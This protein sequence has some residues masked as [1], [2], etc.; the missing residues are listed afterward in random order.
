[1]IIDRSQGFW[2]KWVPWILIQCL[3]DSW[4]G[5][6]SCDQPQLFLHRVGLYGPYPG[7]HPADSL[8]GRIRTICLELVMFQSSRTNAGHPDKDQSRDLG[9]LKFFSLPLYV[10]GLTMVLGCRGSLSVW[11]WLDQ[12]YCLLL[13]SDCQ[14]QPGVL[15][16]RYFARLRFLVSHWGSHTM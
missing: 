16:T 11:Y 7:C 6:R 12:D 15:E 9:V 2:E 10:R 13:R 3:T 4:P 1:M 8:L 5:T 14:N